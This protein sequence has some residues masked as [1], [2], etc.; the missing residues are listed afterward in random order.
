MHI[1]ATDEI[2]ISGDASFEEGT[3]LRTE[4]ITCTGSTFGQRSVTPPN[5][6]NNNNVTYAEVSD[7][8][9]KKMEVEE[10]LSNISANSV[11]MEEK[12]GVSTVD[13]GAIQIFPNPATTLLHI[14]VSEE[15][16]FDI[17]QI[18]VI[19]NLGKKLPFD[20]SKQ[21][22]VSALPNGFYELRIIFSHGL[23]V[24]KTFVKN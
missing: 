3:Y 13:N 14:S 2:E 9:I 4:I 8:E 10:T 5:N 16:F 20:K 15:D 24:V 6:N 21:I 17:I 11:F 19:D 1:L 7:Q 22:N 23:I 18:E 12:S